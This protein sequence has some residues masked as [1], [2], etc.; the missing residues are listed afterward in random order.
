MPKK[1]AGLEMSSV[2]NEVLVHDSSHGK[3]HVLNAIAGRILDLCTGEN[4]PERI[5]DVLS[6]E[7]RADATV[8]RRDVDALLVEFASLQLLEPAHA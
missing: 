5:A 4:T 7:Y 1:I 3:V 2:G 8:V 6:S